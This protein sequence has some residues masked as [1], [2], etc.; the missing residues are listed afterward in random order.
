MAGGYPPNSSFSKKLFAVCLFVAVTP[1][2]LLTVFTHPAYDDYTWAVL[3]LN[4]GFVRT[5]AQLYLTYI[6]RYFS[7]ALVTL[8]PVSFGSVPA[9]KAVTFV[10]VL[11]TGV[12]IFAFVSS[13]LKQS[14]SLL[15]KLIATLFLWALFSNQ[16]PDITEAYFWVTS[17][18]VYQ[19]GGILT[20]CFFALMLMR[21]SRSRLSTA[22]ETLAGVFLIA[23]IVGCNEVS[24]LVLDLLIAV[25]AVTAWIRKSDRRSQWTVFCIVAATCSLVVILAPGNAMRSLSY[26]NGRR[27]FFSIG[28]SVL[29]EARFLSTWLTNGAFMLATIL[30]IP[31]ASA[32][33][34][35]IEILKRIRI[36]PVLS[37]A[38]LLLMVYLGF[39]PAYWGMGTMG[40]HRTVNT[41]Y[42]L[43]LVG[44]FICLVTWIDYLRTRFGWVPPPLPRFSY[45]IGLPLIFLALCF[46]N[47]TKEAI[48]D[49]VSLRAYRYEQQARNRDEWFR[50]CAGKHLQVC[51]KKPITNLP[52]TIT[53]PY[54]ELEGPAELQYWQLQAARAPAP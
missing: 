8:S 22:G 52:T 26:P 1:H 54:F 14:V 37:T 20:L 21:A 36:H 12:S 3:F 24:M 13:A 2:L 35:R 19:V 23:A 15:D 45:F 50:D 31:A 25:I 27:F 44:W 11:L 53:N 47:N 18:L 43:F 6:G 9:Y 16:T 7:T 46:T 17:D 4:R 51:G 28:M 29:Q 39:F 32:L 48:I 38:V 5:Q 33:S 42:F 49:L 10:I 41:V 34:E 30:F 40:Q